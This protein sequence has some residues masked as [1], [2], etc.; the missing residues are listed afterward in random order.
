MSDTLTYACTGAD[1]A[2][3]QVVLN[4]VIDE[5]HRR[6]RVCADTLTPQ[7]DGPALHLTVNDL[8]QLAGDGECQ[9]LFGNV[10]RLGRKVGVTGVAQGGD[11]SLTGFGNTL[12]R[13]LLADGRVLRWEPGP[14]GK[15]VA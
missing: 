9:R 7:W 14:A 2:E 8:P 10:L 6:S 3:A 1:L 5:I 12:I 11:G 15:T 13:D 4:R